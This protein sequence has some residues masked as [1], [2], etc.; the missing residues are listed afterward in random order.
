M[1][2][3]GTKMLYLNV[4]KRAGF[5]GSE[6]AIY[7]VDGV[8]IPAILN[9]PKSATWGHHGSIAKMSQPGPTLKVKAVWMI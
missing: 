8:A 5:S 4:H 1:P 9:A 6:S 2:G 7:S 3:R